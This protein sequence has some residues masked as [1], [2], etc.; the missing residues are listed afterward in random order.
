M[1]VRDYKRIE[2]YH[3]LTE[4]TGVLYSAPEHGEDK[5][6]YYYNEADPRWYL[7]IDSQEAN[8]RFNNPK[9]GFDRWVFVKGETTKQSE[10]IL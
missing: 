4:H 8:E 1:D 7:T 10:D 3:E 9:S 6:I 5:Y 2:F